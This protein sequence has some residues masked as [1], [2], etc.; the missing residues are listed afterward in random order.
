MPALVMAWERRVHGGCR[1]RLRPV[2]WRVGR[3]VTSRRPGEG[4]CPL[5]QSKAEVTRQGHT[6]L[7]QE[8]RQDRAQR[9]QGQLDPDLSGP[10]E[11]SPRLVSE[12]VG[13][14]RPGQAQP[15][16]ALSVQP[17]LDF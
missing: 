9:S 4:G 7:L 2:R 11:S 8:R 12:R 1:R 14:S 5:T 6:P 3:G 13:G 10:A 16:P 17:G 15:S